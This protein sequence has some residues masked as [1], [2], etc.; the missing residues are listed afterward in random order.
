MTCYLEIFS[1]EG[2]PYSIKAEKLIKI[3]GV[4]HKIIKVSHSNKDYYKQK[5]GMSTFPQIFAIS[6]ERKIRKKIGG[7]I[8]LITILKREINN[9][10]MPN[11]VRN[12]LQK[13][14]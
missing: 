9:P 13:N 12:Q 10:E 5:N 2:C 7:C 4:A 11:N 14:F 6:P 3:S 8:E 1:L